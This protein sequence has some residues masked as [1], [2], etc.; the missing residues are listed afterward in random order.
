MKRVSF[1][2]GLLVAGLLFTAQANAREGQALVQSISGEVTMLV[3]GGN[4]LPMQTG[5]MLKSGTVVKTGA[6]SQADL[7]L[8]INGSMLRLAANSELKFNRLAIME[9][10]IEPIA[11]TEMELIRGRVIGNVRKLPMGSS[12]VIKTPKGVAKVKGTVYDIN[13][14]GELIVLSGKVKYTDRANGKEVLIASGGKYV[15][16]R[17]VKAAD[18]EKAESAAA[19]PTDST[20]FPGFT[21]SAPLRQGVWENQARDQR[22]GP[23]NPTQFISP[24]PTFFGD[25][26][27]RSGSAF[28]PDRLEIVLDASAGSELTVGQELKPSDLGLSIGGAAINDNDAIIVVEESPGGGKKLVIKSKTGEPFAAADVAGANAV[29]VAVAIPTAGGNSVSVDVDL[30]APMKPPSLIANVDDAGSAKSINITTDGFTADEA[31]AYIASIEDQ[32][33]DLD[34]FEI[35]GETLNADEVNIITT[36]VPTGDASTPFRVEVEIKPKDPD[37]DLGKIDEISFVPPPVQVVP[38]AIPPPPIIVPPT[39]P[40]DSVITGG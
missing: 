32:F 14:D 29:P 7:F 15:G 24:T 25:L 34:N 37:A 6:N 8:G 38:G 17:E 16:G 35:N 21:I 3:D 10:P 4:W 36:V 1:T 23:V 26:V 39:P 19:A 13:A 22:A 28:S 11:Q 27:V 18:D 30:V 40:V 31:D 12:Y 2:A 5:E 20:G 9:S 33:G